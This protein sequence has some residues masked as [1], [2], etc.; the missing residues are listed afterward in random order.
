MRRIVGSGAAGLL[1]AVLG[2]VHATASDGK[3]DPKSGPQP[4]LVWEVTSPFRLYKT[5]T[6]FRLHERAFQTVHAPG[7]PIPADIVSR[8]ERHLNAP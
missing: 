4:D 5:E 8:M 3:A 2:C 1:V 7:T 6:A